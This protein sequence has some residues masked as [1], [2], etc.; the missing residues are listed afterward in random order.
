[1]NKPNPPTDVINHLAG[2]ESGDRLAEL[3]NQRSD[4][5]TYAQGSFATLLDPEEPAGLSRGERELVALRVA[6]L[7]ANPTL[8]AFHR[9]RLEALGVAPTTVA[10][11]ATFP[12]T[13]AFT[14]REAAILRHVDLLTNEPR[15]ASRAEI[16]ALQE[17]G[18][19]TPAIV[20]L[21]QLVAYLSFS[22]RLL[23]GL[24][25]LGEGE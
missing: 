22:V 20:T 23:A 17:A 21:A 25:I 9:Q 18:L 24:R 6:T 10:A 3:R 15:A 2:L 16:A 4:V 1:M 5:A 13:E 19:S 8:A 12:A 14:Q 11:V 7:N